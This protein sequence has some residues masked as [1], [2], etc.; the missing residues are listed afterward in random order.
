METLPHSCSY[1]EK[2]AEAN[3]YDVSQKE[4]YTNSHMREVGNLTTASLSS[5]SRKQRSKT[6]QKKISAAKERVLQTK[7]CLTEVL[8]FRLLLSEKADEKKAGN[9]N[10]IGLILIC[11]SMHLGHREHRKSPS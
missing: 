7:S 3:V 9:M 2:S 1:P 10:T 6:R 4:K 5:S 8:L 11:E